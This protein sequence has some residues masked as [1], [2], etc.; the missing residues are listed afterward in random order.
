[1]PDTTTTVPTDVDVVRR[2]LIE[3]LDLRAVA[4]PVGSADYRFSMDN[5]FVSP[6]GHVLRRQRFQATYHRRLT[7]SLSARTALFG[8]TWTGV[9]F[10]SVSTEESRTASQEPI[11][12]TF[13]E[14]RTFDY[15]RPFPTAAFAADRH[16]EATTGTF[17]VGDWY[18]DLARVPAVNL[19]AMSTWDILTFEALAGVLACEGLG[20][21]GVRRPV[22][23]MDSTAVH[24]DFKGFSIEHSTFENSAVLGQPVG[25]TLVADTL[26][27]GI[28]FQGVGRLEVGG[29]GSTGRS[30]QGE[31]YY[32][33][34]C[35]LS[36]SDADLVSAEMTEMLMVS[37]KNTAGKLVPMQK[38]RVVRISRVGRP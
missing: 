8:F 5:D 32:L 33:G 28:S 17:H 14:G 20:G 37:M 12:W 26:C 38:R 4:R 30:Q 11:R 19:L 27:T 21:Y 22:A 1:M 31:S 29:A 13:A 6:T 35:L 36:T 18:A 16:R 34:T 24:L 15:Y 23:T 7:G 3:A 10:S 25:L 2:C 9:E